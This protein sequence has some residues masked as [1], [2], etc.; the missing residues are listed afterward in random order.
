MNLNS[1]KHM[2]D[3]ARSKTQKIPSKHDELLVKRAFFGTDICQNKLLLCLI[4]NFYDHFLFLFVNATFAD[5]F[6]VV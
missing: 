4:L 5:Y 2:N 6:S 3:F 1:E